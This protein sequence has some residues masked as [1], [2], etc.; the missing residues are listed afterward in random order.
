[1]TKRV[2]V[3]D[4]Y[5][6]SLVVPYLDKHEFRRHGVIRKLLLQ[7][8]AEPGLVIA[9]RLLEQGLTHRSFGL[10]ANQLAPQVRNAFHGLGLLPR[11]V[12]EQFDQIGDILKG[13]YQIAYWHKWRRVFAAEF[14]HAFS[15]LLSADAKFDSDPSEWLS[16]QDSF[17]DALFRA[18]QGHMG[19][20][21]LSGA[22]AITNTFG[23]LIDYGSLLDPNKVFAANH[24]GIAVPFRAA[25]VRRNGLPTSHPYEKKTGKQTKYLKA[26]ER[27][28]LAHQLGSAYREIVS[29][30]DAHI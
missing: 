18:L 3:S 5:L 23:E 30:L 11:T 28:D 7:P 4:P 12:S 8:Q 25:H 6:Q 17:N 22:C 29:L 27:T 19:R 9:S 10:R 26:K 20:L 21:T 13:R 2:L 15:M 24:P 14:A 16:W 1:V